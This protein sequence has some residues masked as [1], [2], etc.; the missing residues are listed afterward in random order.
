MTVKL[1]TADELNS[2]RALKPPATTVDKDI[3]SFK[4]ATACKKVSQPRQ[5]AKSCSGSPRA[6]PQ[7]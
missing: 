4:N 3:S 5:N 7:K 2:R 1:M 6:S